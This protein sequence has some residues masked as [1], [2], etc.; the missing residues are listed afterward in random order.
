MEVA[1]LDARRLGRI[2]LCKTPLTEPPISEL[3]FDPILSMPDLADFSPRLLK[4]TCP[5]KAL[6]LD[7]SFSAGIGNYIAG[8]GPIRVAHVLVSF[9]T[10]FPDEVLYHAR[11]HPEQRCNSLSE[12]QI[13]A[14]HQQIKDVCTIAVNANA[15]YTKFPD[16]WLFR[17]RW[18][19]TTSFCPRFAD[20]VLM[21]LWKG[22]GKGKK[23]KEGDD[24]ILKLVRIPSAVHTRCLFPKWCTFSQT[25]GL[26]LSDGS[27]WAAVLRRTL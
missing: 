3:G 4:R 14:L 1:F 26:Q 17:H 5:I 7:Q 8:E 9:V 2:R 15:D 10:T 22:K 12:E 21:S 27:P 13:R 19:N 24:S 20:S 25:V 18:V 16:D 11:V 23:A 6:L